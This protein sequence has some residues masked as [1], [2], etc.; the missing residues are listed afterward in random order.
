MELATRC[1][2]LHGVKKNMLV[3]DPFNGVGNAT[4]SAARLGLAA[5]GIDL[6]PA[7]CQEASISIMHCTQRP[8]H[9]LSV[10]LFVRYYEW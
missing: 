8:V 7:Y 9:M 5:I 6:D 2:K 10:L 4:S 3:L 1:I